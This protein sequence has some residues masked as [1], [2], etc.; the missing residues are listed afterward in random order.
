MAA[1]AGRA[2]AHGPGQ[3]CAG[4]SH[5]AA[6]RE[7]RGRR[8][9]CRLR[10][11]AAEAGLR[12]GGAQWVR[13]ARKRRHEVRGSRR[14]HALAPSRRSLVAH[15]PPSRLVR[16]GGL[17]VARGEAPFA[18]LLSSLLES[19][20]EEKASSLCRYPRRGL[21]DLEDPRLP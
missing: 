10:M 17:E 1:H 6:S 8:E 7:S 3:H 11:P 5:V 15:V 12:G 19:G 2:R 21:D 14:D 20:T 13:R 9:G 4:P 16:Q 18:E